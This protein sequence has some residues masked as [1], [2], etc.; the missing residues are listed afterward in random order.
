MKNP[1]T[2]SSVLFGAMLLGAMLLNGNGCTPAQRSTTRTV[3]DVVQKYTR[4]WR[5]LLEYDERRLPAMAWNSVDSVVGLIEQR[6]FAVRGPP[7]RKICKEC[8]L[9]RLCATER[10][11]EAFD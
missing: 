3:L 5:L 4:A 6:E 1:R 11:I 8:D 10:I 7:E 2:R 9:K